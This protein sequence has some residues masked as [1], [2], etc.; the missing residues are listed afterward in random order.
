[1]IL[2]FFKSI[3]INPK[4][5]IVTWVIVITLNQLFIFG[6][7]FAPY[8]LIAALPHTFIISTILIY[9][10]TNDRSK[11]SFKNNSSRDT[12]KNKVHQIN[13]SFDAKH[14]ELLKKLMLNLKSQGENK[15]TTSTQK[16]KKTSIKIK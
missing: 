2:S 3:F 11:K 15:S 13:Q 6:A 12:K 8:C 5:F 10:F 7:C 9:L 1:V 14:H 16:D 4:N